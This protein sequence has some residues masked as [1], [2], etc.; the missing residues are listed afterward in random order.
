MF[1]GGHAAFVRITEHDVNH[2]VEEERFAMLATEVLKAKHEVLVH[3]IGSVTV[4]LS[5]MTYPADDLVMVGQMG[6]AVL[7]AIDAF[8]VEVY[9]VGEAHLDY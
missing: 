3:D 7:A 4:V 8:A 1:A 6:L 2:V 5:S 9:V